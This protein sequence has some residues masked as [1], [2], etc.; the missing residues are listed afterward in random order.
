MISA[1]VKKAVR[2]GADDEL[3]DVISYYSRVGSDVAIAC[4][5]VANGIC[6]RS[7][8]KRRNEVADSVEYISQFVGDNSIPVFGG[9]AYARN[10]N[11][12][13]ETLQGLDFLVHINR[14]EPERHREAIEESLD[15]PYFYSGMNG[16]NRKTV[17]NRRDRKLVKKLLYLNEKEG[18]P[19]EVFYNKHHP[20]FSES[21]WEFF[22]EYDREK[23]IQNMGN[24]RGLALDLYHAS[25]IRDYLPEGALFIRHVFETKKGKLDIDNLVI[26]SLGDLVE[27]FHSMQDGNV[28]VTLFNHALQKEEKVK[29][30]A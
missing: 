12:N 11:V 19:L 18:V 24:A 22:P 14:Y 8:Q 21:V 15:Y 4:I 13:I 28:V 17:L 25:L 27:M 10:L 20:E 26:A 16:Y 5:E 23:F 3:G 7:Q 30:I 2:R 29:E 1:G 6:H 9:I